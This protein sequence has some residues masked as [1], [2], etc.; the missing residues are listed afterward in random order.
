MSEHDWTEVVGAIGIFTLLTTVIT[1]TIVQLA[2]SW[3]A[4]AMLAREDSFRTIAEASVRAQEQTERHLAELGT[5]LAELDSRMTSLER[6]LKEV[7]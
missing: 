2:T 1:V 6:I 4:K 7:E 3:R 5:R